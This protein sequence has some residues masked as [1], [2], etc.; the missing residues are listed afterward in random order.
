[1]CPHVPA[2]RRIRDCLAHSRERLFTV[3]YAQALA[4][5]REALGALNVPNAKTFAFH[6]FRRGL[7][8]DLLRARTPLRDILAACDWSSQTFAWYLS[9][10]QID[11]HAVLA[12]AADLSDDDDVRNT[13]SPP[14]SRPLLRQLHWGTS[15]D[16]WRSGRLAAVRES[17]RPL[18]LGGD[19]QD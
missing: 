2:E 6:A 1:M 17:K 4:F 3:S 5:L 18:S 8:Q 9:R 16:A 10:E 15:R 12:A 11:E 7:S 19:A 14:S 13:S